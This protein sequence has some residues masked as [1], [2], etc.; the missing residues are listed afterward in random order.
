MSPLGAI[1]V[2]D[3]LRPTAAEGGK[4]LGCASSPPPELVPS[5]LRGRRRFC[6]ETGGGEFS[7]VGS[8]SGGTPIPSS[9]ERVP[10][11]QQP[12]AKASFPFPRRRELPQESRF[13]SSSFSMSA[14]PEKVLA[15]VG[16]RL[17]EPLN[18]DPLLK[19]LK[20]MGIPRTLEPGSVSV[21]SSCRLLMS[22]FWFFFM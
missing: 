7:F 10:G 3:L 11:S 22:L 20:V 1:H 14:P 19:L 17:S 9:C 18:K 16:R 5:V 21:S 12:P 13:P 8:G 4:S 6:H 2:A 15:D